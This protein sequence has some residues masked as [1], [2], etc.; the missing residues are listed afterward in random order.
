M[1]DRKQCV[2]LLVDDDADYRESL[3][4]LFWATNESFS[5]QVLEASDG[6][7]ATDVLREQHVD[8]VLLDHRMPGENGIDCIGRFLETDAHLPI[9]MVTGQGDESTAVSAMRQG[10]MDYLVKGSISAEALM[11][12]IT[13]AIEKTA[14]RKALEEHRQALLIAEQQRVMIESL[15]AACHHLGQPMSVMTL[16]LGNMK[17]RRWDPEVQELIDL[18]D[19]AVT[20]ANDILRRLQEASVYRT[21]PY[22]TSVEERAPQPGDRILTI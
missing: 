7:Q 14:M 2:V 21:E 22:L 3:R 12:A 1:T 13:N 5:V 9:V 17:A 18:C 19:D 15:G 6:V 20:A 10:A 8:C 4:R 11:R 16:C